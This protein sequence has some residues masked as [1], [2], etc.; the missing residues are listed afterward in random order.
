MTRK[1]VLH[2]MIVCIVF[3]LLTVWG[4]AASE[5][6]VPGDIEL[7]AN[8][9]FL[10]QVLTELYAE[11]MITCSNDSVS[12]K[13]SD[14]QAGIIISGENTQLS[15]T[16]FTLEKSFD[17]GNTVIGRIRVDGL[18][19]SEFVTRV[20]ILLDGSENP[21]VSVSLPARTGEESRENC[22]NQ[23]VDV[24]DLHL[25]G[26]HTVQ[27]RVVQC[28]G[29]EVRAEGSA[30]VYLRD[31]Q[32]VADTIP[33][34]EVLIDESLGTI[35]EMNMDIAH[36]TK[37]YG[38]IRIRVPDSY[39]NRYDTE[40]EH[41]EG[42]TYPLE[43][44]RGRGNST[45]S[46]DGKHPYKIKLASSEDLFFMGSSKHWALIANEYDD[47][48]T[49]NNF[50]YLL[51]EK[52]GFANPINTVCVDVLMNGEYLGSYTL[53]ETVRVEKN[54]VNID[55]LEKE[56]SLDDN[57]V[58]GGYLL[59][60]NSYGSDDGEYI[61]KTRRG[62]EFNVDSP[63]SG[64]GTDYTEANAYIQNYMQRVEDAIYGDVN[65]E[66]GIV[67]D[68][69][70]L[71]DLDSA[72]AYYCIQEF[73]HNG[74]FMD[75]SSTYCYKV[76]N[77]KLF[78]GP[79]WDFDIAYPIDFAY[80]EDGV[81]T[82]KWSGQKG[83]FRRLLVND[84]FRQAVCE[85]WTN[86]MVPVL[87]ELLEDGGEYDQNAEQIAYSAVNNFWTLGYGKSLFDGTSYVKVTSNPVQLLAVY[88]EQSDSLKKYI[89]DHMEW[90]NENLE[91][92]EPIRVRVIFKSGDEIC[93]IEDHFDDEIIDTLPP[94]PKSPEEDMVFIGW[95]RTC[96]RDGQESE[97]EKCENM[98]FVMKDDA[99]WDEEQNIYVMEIRA[100]FEKRP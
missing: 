19:M 46:A 43:F 44:I 70:D 27:F 61:I 76:R 31:I 93:V 94:D 12:V 92:I 2:M 82:D 85:Y 9:I 34:V 95:Y 36:E 37:C 87:E 29:E 81:F 57:T 6:D 28:D 50:T 63:K 30:E 56:K 54:R 26:K 66:L 69:F 25:T 38:D 11:N 73:S 13:I 20:D 98:I 1:N 60:A 83:W 96:I 88:K 21:A 49:R 33:V 17:F 91:S 48:L 55:N 10:P 100:Q 62:Y 72:V 39:H 32:F 86:E 51:G 71:M 75:T 67:E 52:L 16:I 15:Q 89:I 78:W 79:L 68:P 65:P 22:T 3:I 35:R 99:V 47:S 45:W 7:A 59:G 14:D 23:N 84:T 4:C 97:P 41:Y 58:T 18:S 24:S 80:D 42:G 77:G 64:E 53:S 5:N 40:T 90:M 74:D 8:D